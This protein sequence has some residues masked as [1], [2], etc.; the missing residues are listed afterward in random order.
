MYE[1]I[2]KDQRHYRI[3]SATETNSEEVVE[4]CNEF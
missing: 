3:S 2:I 1:S 4:Y